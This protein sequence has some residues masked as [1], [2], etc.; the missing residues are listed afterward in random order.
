MEHEGT[1]GRVPFV[2]CCVVQWGIVH[3][4]RREPVTIEKLL[5]RMRATGKSEAE[6]ALVQRAHEY[7]AE[8]HEG[9]TRVSGEPYITHCL[10][11]AYLLADLGLPQIGGGVIAA[12]LLHDVLEDCEDR[13]ATIEELTER[14]GPHVASWVNGVTKL[15]EIDRQSGLIV[16]HIMPVRDDR[17]LGGHQRDLQ[18]QESL[19]KLL[20]A[21]ADDPRVIYIKLA[22]RL[23]NM[24]TLGS[25]RPEQQRRTAQETMEIFAPLAN[26]IGIWA[27]KAELEDLAFRYL[28]PKK[29]YEIVEALNAR[30]EERET[31]IR[32]YREKLEAL[33]RREGIQHFEIQAR[34]KHIYSI[35]RK[36]Q[37]KQV[38]VEEVHDREALRVLVDTVNECYIVLGLVHRTW[39]PVPGEMD[40][41]IANTKPN[42]YQ[43]LHTAVFG[44]E[45][46][47]LEI[48]IRT[49]EM[50]EVAEKGV[51]AHWRYK[52]DGITLDDSMVSW[53]NWMRDSA[54][55]LKD[56]SSAVFVDTVREEL[57]SDS[58]VV[59]TPEGKVIELPNGATPV[60]FAYRV[61]TE[62]GHSCRGAVVINREHREGVIVPL[63]Y[64]LQTGDI[65]RILRGRQGPSRDWL[66][67]ELGYVR[68]PRAK[69][70]IRQWFRKLDREENI[71]IGR[72][73]WERTLKQLRLKFDAVQA[74]ELLRERGEVYKD[75]EAFFLAIG[76]GDLSVM[77]VVNR[78]EQHLK[79]LAEEAERQ[80]REATTIEPP[81]APKPVSV[82]IMESGDLLSRRAKCC[83]PLPGQAIRG[84]ITRGRGVSIHA[85]DCKMLQRLIQEEPERIV[86]VKWGVSD[87]LPVQLVIQSRDRRSMLHEITG[88]FS[89]EKVNI[90]G[91]STGKKDR[92]NIIPIYISFE[93]SDLAH[94]TRLVEKL[95][96]I[97]DVIKVER[98][99]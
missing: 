85:A 44:D 40:D 65:V 48:Q 69:Q 76:V 26:R 22:D 99:G 8:M 87:R 38:S 30:R 17:P 35:Y 19:R 80:E 16:D 42:K 92:Y 34:A 60:D 43:S 72:A 88:V 52:E 11:V 63:N 27:W 58:V 56:E 29:F 12:A 50:H 64:K 55:A 68:T 77:H 21:M 91:I 47:T 71:A 39:P 89:N 57:L 2:F 84:Y 10:E 73:M 13:G 33:L 15:K 94:L 93:I 59:F 61:H 28:E 24:R 37:R 90:D 46:E 98:V 4:S 32:R 83:N 25:M 45:G 14:F 51:A 7:A 96:A 86:D 49:F 54:E 1:P 62:L 79:A 20:I 66:V 74:I 6:C 53:I 31:R 41:Y 78:I 97:R 18:E 5:E 81:V 82:N 23:H 67:D 9:Q 36:M 95:E 70:K 3:M 75:E